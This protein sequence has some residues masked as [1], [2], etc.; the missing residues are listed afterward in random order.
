MYIVVFEHHVKEGQEDAFVAKWQSGSDVIQK[1]P[2]A[3]GTR[4]YK[5]SDREGVMYAIA[6]WESKESRDTAI[7]ELSKLAGA[8][9][10]LHGHEKYVD[11][12]KVAFSGELVSKSLP[13]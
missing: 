1:H 7:D 6:Q 11:S 5:S 8:E 13:P 12:Y 9:D 10:L 2:R 3:L 4:L